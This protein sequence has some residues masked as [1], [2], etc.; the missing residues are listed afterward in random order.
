MQNNH[1]YQ[2]I[3]RTSVSKNKALLNKALPISLTAL[4]VTC[5][6]V[7]MPAIA[8]NNES[9]FESLQ[10]VDDSVTLPEIPKALL[11]NAKAS[12]DPAKVAAV[13]EAALAVFPDSAAAITS[14][15]DQI[16]EE[17]TPPAELAEAA[18]E[19]APTGGF[20]AIGPWEGKVVGTAAR[21]T[22]NSINTAY[23]LAFDAARKAGKYTHN[24]TGTIDIAT[25]GALDNNGDADSTLTQKRWGLAYQLDY[26]IN[27]RTYAYARAS[28][29]ED[30]FSGFDY[31]LFGGG[32][33]GYFLYDNDTLKWKVEGGP[34]YRYSLIDD[35]SETD[36]QFAIYAASE[37]DWIIREGLVFEQDFN[38]IWTS[39]TTTLVSQTSITTAI[40]E[41]ISIGASYLYRFETD[42]PL[43][44]VRT[45][46]LLRASINYGF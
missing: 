33:L 20:F 10:V 42:P 17:L 29:E 40:S 7:S 14:Y 32:G 43:G 3:N 37:T 18:A 23:G 1:E 28:Y 12:G 26:E 38:G 46:T 35:T 19:E 4:T 25:S 2:N 15:S 13:A 24:V 31:R 9:A 21:A 45:D 34:G 44:R 8:A 27:D 36:S 6:L 30:Q 22:G 39:S 16:I 11:E 41:S 5:G